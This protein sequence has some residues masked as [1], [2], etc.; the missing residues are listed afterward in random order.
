MGTPWQSFISIITL[1]C[2]MIIAGLLPGGSLVASVHVT[3]LVHTWHQWQPARPDADTGGW[4]LV[5]P[6]SAEDTD[7][8]GW[9]SF[10]LVLPS[11]IRIKMI[12]VHCFDSLSP[13]LCWGYILMDNGASLLSFCYFHPLLLRPEYNGVSL[14]DPWLIFT[15]SCYSWLSRASKVKVYNKIMRH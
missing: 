15:N 5:L 12:E 4:H 1:H 2:I 13:I 8:R 3:S 11:S 14:G 6:S 7:T 10:I 9:R